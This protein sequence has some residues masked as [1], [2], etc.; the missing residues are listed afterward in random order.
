M[1]DCCI[2]CFSVMFYLSILIIAKITHSFSFYYFFCFN[3]QLPF[4][5]MCALVFCSFLAYTLFLAVLL[6][7]CFIT[8]QL[9]GPVCCSL[10]FYNAKLTSLEVEQRMS[11]FK[12][13]FFFN[14][15]LNSSDKSASSNAV[16]KL[17]IICLSYCLLVNTTSVQFCFVVACC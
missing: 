2:S 16:V 1:L 6:S 9:Y 3:D 14:F 15:S 13:W 17:N 4:S 7:H 12:Y 8:D 10:F 5:P 11:D